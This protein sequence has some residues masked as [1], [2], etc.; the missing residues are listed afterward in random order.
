[1]VQREKIRN[2][3]LEVDKI[4]TCAFIHQICEKI[5]KDSSDSCDCLGASIVSEF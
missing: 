1:M 3:C 5:S 2:N 4:K